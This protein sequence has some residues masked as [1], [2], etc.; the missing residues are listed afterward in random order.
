[1]AEHKV[2]TGTIR[3]TGAEELEYGQERARRRAVQDGV[4][5]WVVP[6]VRRE[7]VDSDGNRSEQGP[8]VRGGMTHIE[9]VLHLRWE[10][11][12]D[13]DDAR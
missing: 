13:R 2:Y 4:P 10:W 1:M 9:T 12:A 5:E 6:T 3:G 7:Y 11:E 8:M